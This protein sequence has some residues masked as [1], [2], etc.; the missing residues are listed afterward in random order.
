VVVA[1]LAESATLDLIP[2]GVESKGIWRARLIQADVQG[3]SGYYP[4][5]VLRRDGPIAFPA[6][7]HVYLDH[8]TD[9]EEMERPERSVR[10][11]AG[12]LVDGA[13]Y[14]EA[15]DGRGLFAR[16]QFLDDVKDRIRSLAHHVGLSIRAAGEIEDTATGRVV[17]SIREGL[18][19]DVVTRPGAGGRLIY[20]TESNASPSVQ[21]G[22]VT[23]ASTAPSG[24]TDRD[25]TTEVVALRESYEGKMDR[26]TLAITNLTQ[27]LRDKQKEQ[28]RQLQEAQSAGK[29]A[30]KLL[31]A[32]LPNSSRVRLAENYQAGQDL[33][34]SIEREKEYLNSV[35][36]ESSNGEIKKDE[37]HVRG[38]SLGLSESAMT[39]RKRTSDDFSAIEDV[40][41][42]KF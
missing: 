10:D 33:D 5:E 3:S 31:A 1:T 18:S 34:S 37:L 39:Q 9:T 4:A 17:R 6:G 15:T 20:M 24:V 27:L 35:L 8:P 38:T 36:S 30:A 25:L 42:G 7:T 23:T 21:G 32:D 12:Y 29:V 11:L 41:L 2:I 26:F 16:I 13:V 19:V 22:G 28:D 40:L 14:E